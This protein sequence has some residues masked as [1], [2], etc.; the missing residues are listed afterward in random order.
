MTRI[1]ANNYE[2]TLNGAILNTD[3]SM[4]ITSVT[5]FP[6]IGAGVTCNITLEDGGVREIVKATARSGFVVT[7]VRAQEGTSAVGFSTGSTV[8]IRATRDSIDSKQDSLSGASL[9]T[10]TV[11]VSDLVLLQDV[12][13]SDN[14]KTCTVQ[15][16]VD[17]ASVGAGGTVPTGGTGLTS[18]TAYAVMCGGTTS[19][20]PMQQVVGVGT[21]GQVLT[22][23]AGGQLPTWQ[24][25][26][27]GSGALLGITTISD[28]N[29]NVSISLLATAAAVN[30]LT[31][32]NSIAGSAVL[33]Y[34]AGASTNTTLTLQGKGTKGVAIGA[35]TGIAK[36]SI[37]NNPG[38]TGIDIWQGLANDSTSTGCGLQALVQTGTGTGNSAFGNLSGGSITSGSDNSYF[39]KSTGFGVAS[40]KQNCG[41]GSSSS[42]G[43]G[44]D[45]CSAFGYACGGGSSR[46][47]YFGSQAGNSGA[48][49]GVA[50]S[51]SAGATDNT[52]MGYRSTADTNS[53]VGTIAIGANAVAPKA[54]G[55]TS[56]TDGPGIAIG[57]A[58]NKVGFHG[59]GSI[60]ASSGASQGYMQ[61]KINGTL[62]KIN[63]LAV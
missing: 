2:T 28:A 55:S 22:S 15:A 29:N 36:L 42:Q 20:N 27:A 59:D 1:H 12:D 48:S 16:I 4:T 37:S 51:Q 13:D 32:A 62:Y 45:D 49:G 19:T 21:A 17:L 41:F 5:G 31:V 8:S 52:F 57:S 3:L 7:I 44:A 14:L 39:G 46:N 11:T 24:N 25:V 47:S 40:G 50:M 30:Y 53:A 56:I 63:L 18:L 35:G 26:S 60:F 10:T 61:I 23:N 43:S 9:A 58:A 33:M 38:S 34:P 6:A 54:T